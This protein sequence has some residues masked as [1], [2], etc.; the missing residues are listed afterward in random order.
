MRTV[1]IPVFRQQETYFEYV[2]LLKLDSQGHSCY[3]KHLEIDI[4]WWVYLSQKYLLSIYKV[5][6]IELGTVEVT[7]KMQFPLSR[8]FI[9]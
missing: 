3:S 6:I 4:D 5:L 9:V 7:C 8:G 2:H 1:Y